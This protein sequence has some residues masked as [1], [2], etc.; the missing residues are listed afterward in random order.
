[1]SIRLVL[2]LLSIWSSS[3]LL[4]AQLTD[5]VYLDLHNGTDYSNSLPYTVC[6]F[7]DGYL[8]SMILFEWDDSKKRSNELVYADREGVIERRIVS[9]PGYAEIIVFWLQ[10]NGNGA[11]MMV[12]MRSSETSKE[13]VALVQVDSNLN[14]EVKDLRECALEQVYNTAV[15]EHTD[16]VASFY[17]LIQSIHTESGSVRYL[18]PIRIA[19]DAESAVFTTYD[20]LQTAVSRMTSYTYLPSRNKYLLVARSEESGTGPEWM[21][22]VDEAG[23]V[24]T[25]GEAVM[26]ELINDTTYVYNAKFIAVYDAGDSVIALQIPRA[27]N[28]RALSKVTL[29][30][31]SLRY[32]RDFR[33]CFQDAIRGRQGF[34]AIYSSQDV[35]HVHVSSDFA[36][37]TNGVTT[38]NRLYVHLMAP[39]FTMLEEGYVDLGHEVLVRDVVY[40]SGSIAVVGEEVSTEHEDNVHGYLLIVDELT[41]STTDVLVDQEVLSIS[42]NPVYG[43]IDQYIKVNIKARDNPQ[44]RDHSYIITSMDG[45]QVRDGYLISSSSSIQVAGLTSGMYVISI[46]DP[47]GRIVAAAKFIMM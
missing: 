7:E 45:K 19:L 44:W 34:N 30:S 24:D 33:G 4:S 20:T 22:L 1:M 21:Y 39:D 31:D 43:D 47:D 28:E 16:R 35:G 11:L 10:R 23:G 38:P 25:L 42:P 12:G 13:Y 15:L 17:T 36:D 2:I 3:I 8:T 37:P 32:G 27:S 6:D 29:P 41:T 14:L 40:S 9:L 5:V 26:R 46:V 18:P